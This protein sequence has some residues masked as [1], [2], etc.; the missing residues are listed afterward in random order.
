MIEACSLKRLEQPL[1][2]V[3]GDGRALHANHRGSV[4]LC[5]KSGSLTRKCKLHNVLFVPQLAYCLLSVSKAVEKGIKFTFN[6]R[7]CVVRAAN[8]RLITIASKSGNLF[9]VA[10]ADQ[11]ECQK[12]GDKQLEQ[13]HVSKEELWHRRYGHLNTSSLK[14][15]AADE[16]VKEFDYHHATKDSPLC[17]PCCKGKQHKNPFP[18]SSDRRAAN[19]LDLI[20]S[21]VCGKMSSKSLSGAEYFVMFIDDKTRCV[22]LH[23]QEKV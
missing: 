22:G 7:G 4:S 21:D 1:D 5:L 2:V 20:H 12:R 14:E 15:L 10:T 6:E 11:L 8:G 19:P 13:C 16:L 3:L 18:Q 23:H 17:E 9:Q